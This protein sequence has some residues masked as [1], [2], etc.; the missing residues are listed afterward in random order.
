MAGLQGSVDN[1]PQGVVGYLCFFSSVFHFVTSSVSHD[2][3]AFLQVCARKIMR[4]EQ[5]G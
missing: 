2:L 4:S 5:V 1:A 3:P